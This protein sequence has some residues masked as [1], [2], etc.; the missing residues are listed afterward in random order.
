MSWPRLVLKSGAVAT[1][2]YF[3]Y[4]Y[5]TDHRPDWDCYATEKRQPN[6]E[7]IGDNVTEQFSSICYSGFI[8]A[9]VA[10]IVCLVEIVNKF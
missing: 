9:L 2:T 1:L 3:M 8:I 4:S 10:C 6:W 5:A 7:G